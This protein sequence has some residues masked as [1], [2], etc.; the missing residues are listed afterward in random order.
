VIGWLTRRRHED[1]LHSV[2]ST[3]LAPISS[4]PKHVTQGD[5]IRLVHQL[6]ITSTLQGGLGITPGE[7]EW[8]RV[9]T[10]IPLQDEKV[11][12]FPCL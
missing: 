11:G 5:K 8:K 10:I 6:L 12:F 1:F 9:S 7:G 4:T 2:S 3:S